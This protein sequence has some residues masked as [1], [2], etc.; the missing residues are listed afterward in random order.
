MSE[1][2]RSFSSSACP[3]TRT[4]NSPVMVRLDE[5][6]QDQRETA[7]QPLAHGQDFHGLCHVS[8]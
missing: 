8:P 2:L 6:E 4:S 5:N 1:F 3:I 7:G